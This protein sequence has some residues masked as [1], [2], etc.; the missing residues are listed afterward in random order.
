MRQVTC[1]INWFASSLS[2][3]FGFIGI[4]A[5]L[6]IGFAVGVTFRFSETWSLLFNMYLS[7]AAI[8][9]AAT[10]L[11]AQKR[12]T[13]AIQAKLDQIILSGEADNTLVGIERR[14]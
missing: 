13:A 8:V 12:D 4:V 2:T 1:L 10:I 14:A 11:I 3:T 9:I 5:T 7:L 6:F